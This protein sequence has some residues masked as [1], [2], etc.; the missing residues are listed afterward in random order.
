MKTILTAAVLG[1]GKSVEGKVGWAIGHSHADAWKNAHPG[2]RLLALDPSVGNR[3]AFAKRFGVAAEDCFA[4]SAEMYQ[5]IVPDFVSICTWPGLHAPM[6][7][8]AAERGVKGIACEK[9]MALSPLQIEQMIAACEKP[10]EVDA[11]CKEL[12]EIW[13]PDSGFI[14]GS[15]CA[16]APTVPKE[17]IHA[18]VEAARKYGT[19]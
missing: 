12:I 19:R 7:I 11:A 13:K 3:A 18:L 8:E 4:S 6:V 17:N 1:C 10:D 16:L 2:I 5:A 9:P 14:L 15:G